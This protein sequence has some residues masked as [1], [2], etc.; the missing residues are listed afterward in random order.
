[1]SSED[2]GQSPFG[3]PLDQARFRATILQAEQEALQASLQASPATFG[4]QLCLAYNNYFVLLPEGHYHEPTRS[5]Y[6]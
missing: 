2:Q 6:N 5:L 1:M 4:Y 3:T